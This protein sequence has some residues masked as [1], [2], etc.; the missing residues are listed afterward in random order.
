MKL[1]EKQTLSETVLPTATLVSRGRQKILGWA[2]GKECTIH[3]HNIPSVS[4]RRSVAFA[5][6]VMGMKKRLSLLM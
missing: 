4:Q 5:N 3:D 1:Q 6:R 2:Q